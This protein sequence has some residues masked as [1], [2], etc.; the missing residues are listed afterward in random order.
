MENRLLCWKA[1]LCTNVLISKMLREKQSKN[2]R[3]NL[4]AE[5]TAACTASSVVRIRT[6]ETLAIP[7]HIRALCS[8]TLFNSND[9]CVTYVTTCAMTY[10][11]D[12][13]KNV[14]MWTLIVYPLVLWRMPWKFTYLLICP[15]IE[16]S[17]NNWKTISFM[18]QWLKMVIND[19][20]GVEIIT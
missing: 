7:V 20:E 9:M 17:F 2:G 13:H 18:I 15:V 3:K 4:A 6:P 8:S 12:G 14:R 1:V 5:Q 10:A 11:F 19:E 16:R